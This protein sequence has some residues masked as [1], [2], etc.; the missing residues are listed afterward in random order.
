[1]RTRRQDAQAGMALIVVLWGVL[2]L[3]AIAF[4]LAAAVR[5]GVDELNNRKEYMQAHYVA[6]GAIFRAA[7]FLATRPAQGS[8]P[9]YK[10]GQ[11]LISWDDGP[12]KVTVELSDE[13]A[14]IDL[15]KAS[16]ESLQRLFI[17]MGFSFPDAQALVDAVEDWRD[18]DS[19]TR[20]LGAEDSYYLSLPTPYHAANANFQS[21]EELLLVRGVTED[22]F[23][24]GYVV[25]DEGKVT[26]RLG[27]VDCLTVNGSGQSV[28]INYAPYPVL[29]AVPGMEPQVA[30]Y[31]LAGRQQKPFE[32]AS[33]ITRQFPVSLSAV[34]LS[35]LTTQTSLR[36]SLV[37]R[38]SAVDGVSAR[39]RALVQL[40]P[41]D[42][43]PF[44]I[45]SWDDAYVH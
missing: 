21:V 28:N 2:L 24:G 31:I 4:S 10:P 43:A 40:H 26:R 12:G 36:I 1:M 23:Y 38:S 32:S 6:R 42:G 39:V 9:E 20:A 44:R 18:A 45:L 27:L 37:A 29:M 16:E 25:G 8:S 5:A 7:L 15:N 22:A 19:V 17:E 11:Q 33:E 34:T 14:K 35:H 30:N 3:A 13:S 41:D